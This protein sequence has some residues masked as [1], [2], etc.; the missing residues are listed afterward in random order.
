M[1]DEEIEKAVLY[2]IIFEKEECEL[3]EEDFVNQTHKKIIKAINSLKAQKEEISI[4]SIK[5]KIDTNSNKILAYLAGLGDYISLSKFETVYILLKKYTKKR[6]IYSL[7][8][9]I[10]SNIKDIENIDNYTEKVIS[11]LQKNSII[12]FSVLPF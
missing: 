3:T 1:S 9:E 7:A 12:R 11:N 2:Y 8:R 4:L 6:Q 10:Q 5:N